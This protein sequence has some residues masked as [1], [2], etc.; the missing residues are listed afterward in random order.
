MIIIKFSTFATVT[1]IIWALYRI[2]NN[3]KSKGINVRRE[4]LLNLLYFYVV[5]V[6]GVTFFPFQITLGSLLPLEI[7]GQIL[8]RTFDLMAVPSIFYMNLFGNIVLFMPLGILIS[9]L[10][11]EKANFFKVIFGGFI[12]SLTIE[13]CQL[14]IDYRIFDV[15]DLIFN[16]IGYMMGYFI[17]LL[18]RM[19]RLKEIKGEI[20]N[21]KVLSVIIIPLVTTMVT[22]GVL[23]GC[24]VF[25]NS[26]GDINYEV[27]HFEKYEDMSEEY[28]ARQHTV[29][30]KLKDGIYTK[31]QAMKIAKNIVG[32]EYY[33]EEFESVRIFMYT[34]EAPEEYIIGDFDL[35]IH[36]DSRGVFEYMNSQRI[37]I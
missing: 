13:C 14:F 18:Y 20:E 34:G 35:G 16:T 7:N 9:L 25:I 1:L 11:E 6:M 15:D 27:L 24:N 21:R 5:I 29:K 8:T 30:I 12:I 33:D 28:R 37:E 17:C 3:V 36:I 31:S 2:Y 4:V 10:R 22:L 23:I 32:E 19:L 26:N